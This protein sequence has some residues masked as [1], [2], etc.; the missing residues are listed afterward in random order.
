[1]SGSLA[2]VVSFLRCCSH[3]QLHQSLSL[4][5]LRPHPHPR[6]HVRSKVTMPNELPRRPNYVPIHGILLLPIPAAFL[7]AMIYYE[8][9]GVPIARQMR[10]EA[11]A[12][13]E[14]PVDLPAE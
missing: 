9:A 6:L 4:P 8:D 14:E 5:H 7:A 12:S 3:R 2:R 13:L 11:H 1:M 10:L